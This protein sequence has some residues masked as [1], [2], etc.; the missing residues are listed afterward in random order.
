VVRI[1][2]MK[3][4]TGM[5]YRD[6]CTECGV[7]YS[8]FMRVK[9][10]R[11]RG[12]PAVCTPGPKKV[13][14]FDLRQ[15]AE[16]VR[17]LAHRRK[18]THGT[19]GLIAAYA[20]GISRRDIQR[21]VTEARSERLHERR[22]ALRQVT[23]HVPCLVWAVDGTEETKI[24]KGRPYYLNHQD[25]GSKYILPPL[26]EDHEACGETVAGHLAKLMKEY[27]APLFYKRDNKG[28]LNHPAV[29]E[30][31]EENLVIP[32][33][34]PL[35]YPEYNGS[36]EK[37]NGDLKRRVRENLG[38]VTVPTYLAELH[39]CLAAHEL[40]HIPRACL[41]ARTACE[42]WRAGAPQARFYTR[43]KRKE[44]MDWIRDTASAILA[45]L[46]GSDRRAEEKA[47]RLAAEAWLQANGFITVSS[48]RKC[49]P[50][51]SKNGLIIT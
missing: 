41:A 31:L 6:L 26:V 40:N 8:S 47:W 20:D 19:S 36:L 4:E 51:S 12:E 13:E 35:A 18:R 27:G 1:E 21:M 46:D 30:V 22:A 23:W 9:G 38:G 29:N 14:P 34:S 25:L 37:T 49:Y 15:L 28:N 24:V 2:G 7:P 5:S 48:G 44:V 16:E 11:R 3:R 45:Q 10:R 32:L 50:I 43:R 17:S 42:V 39:A 33:N